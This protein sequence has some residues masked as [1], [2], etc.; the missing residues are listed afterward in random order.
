MTV[1]DRYFLRVIAGPFLFFVLVFTGVIWLS[2]SLRVI[3]TVV[4]NGQSA[5]VFLEFTALLLPTVFA[6]VLPV[7]G[8]AAVLYAVNRLFSDSEIV[9]VFA[10][11]L[12]GVSLLRPVAIFGTLVLLA[13]MATTLYLMPTTKRI[14]QER[15]TEVRG[16]VAAAFLR[17]GAFVSPVFKVTIYLRT[18][19][20]P[21]ELLGVFVHDE[22]DP[23]QIVT[24]T[25]ERAVLVNDGNS[26]KIVMFDGL[27]QSKAARPDAPI[28][29]LRFERLSYDLGQL[30]SEQGPRQRK[31]SEF[32]LPELL[33]AGEGETGPYS[34][35][36]YRA[37]AHEA[38]SGPLYALALPFLGAALIV[39]LGFRRQGFA[40]RIVLA[41]VAALGLRLLGLAAKSA[42]NAEAALWP[43][44]YVPPVLGIAV[45]VY[46][47][48]G[49]G[50]MPRRPSAPGGAAPEDADDGP[51]DTRGGAA[52]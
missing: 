36:E 31:P 28:S 12:S 33:G 35:G 21:G 39:S 38:L 27:A 25:A 2:Q 42:T 14:M 26:P 9:V 23:D 10:A 4:N 22:R 51:P 1:L 32:Y 8:F 17:E 3:D 45:A 19:G 40:G 18:M 47:M 5:R 11:G 30:N 49:R 16:D 6:I 46:M 24:Y 20:R 41:A 34:L 48:S 44:M 29:V 7:A 13:L 52:R 43:L 37:E 50:M 15:I